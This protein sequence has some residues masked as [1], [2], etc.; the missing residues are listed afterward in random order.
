MLSE[1]LGKTSFSLGHNLLTLNSHFIESSPD[2]LVTDLDHETGLYW[3]WTTK[4]TIFS[5]NA[6][7][8]TEIYD[9]IP[10]LID[11]ATT[12]LSVPPYFYAYLA[13]MS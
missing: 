13:T 2:V 8:Y 11:T 1:F 12:V 5:D 9:D 10:A 3:L 4:I 7:L 6:P